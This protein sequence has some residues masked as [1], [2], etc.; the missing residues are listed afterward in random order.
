MQAEDL[1]ARLALVPNKFEEWTALGKVNIEDWISKSFDTVQVR[2]EMCRC[3]Q[4][5]MLNQDWE[6]NFRA[7]KQRRKLCEKVGAW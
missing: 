2:V 7:L 6:T 3:V 4:T 5:L 1:F